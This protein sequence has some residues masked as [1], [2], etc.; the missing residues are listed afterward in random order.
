M[1]P[2]GEHLPS[3]EIENK[4]LIM[5]IISNNSNKYL[6]CILYNDSF[7]DFSIFDMDI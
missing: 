2:G 4:V 7:L 3:G 6:D 1:N 5:R